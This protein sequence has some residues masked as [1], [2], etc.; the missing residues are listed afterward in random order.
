MGARISKIATALCNLFERK[1]MNIWMFNHYAQPDTLPGGTRHF[2]LART[3]VK[4]GH[5]V[6]IFAASFH[7]TLLRETQT[8][9]DKPYKKE[10][11]EGVK[12]VW[13]KTFP[14]QKNDLRRMINIL[15]YAWRLRF[16]VAKLRLKKPDVIIG[17]TVHPFAPLVASHFA[18]RYR[19]PF[20]FEIRDLWPQTFIDMQLWKKE[21][22][23][24]KL[25]YWIEKSTV[26]R[27]DGII[28]LSPLTIR[29]LEKR[30]SYPEKKILLLPNGVGE[31]FLQE[32]K[33]AEDDHFHIVYVGGID[34]VHGLDFLVLIAKT[35]ATQPHI[36]FDLYGNGKERGQLEAL[37][38]REGLENVRWHGSVIKSRVPAILKEADALFVSTSN[39]LY[40]SEN[41][42]YEYMA[43]ATPLIVAAEGKHNNPAEKIGCGISIPRDNN[44]VAA[45]KIRA[46]STMESK[47][48]IL[49]GKRGRAYVKSHRLISHLGKQLLDFLQSIP[50]S[51]R[52]QPLE[53][54][55]QIKG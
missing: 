34:R 6:T 28:V 26:K 19:V 27:S 36:V 3:L 18:K 46:L 54:G 12:F 14:Y 23:Q 38:K 11:V 24:A 49:M 8:Y 2:D 10:Q 39:V 22:L 45:E 16:A 5:R 48:R 31:Q 4:E 21:G 37:C 32:P 42:L 20:I 50:K 9:Q 15:S 30:Y 52:R 44:A 33:T 41:K 25:F 53:S 17:S 47:Q 51:K 35:L 13:V 1:P 40:G 55:L 29:Y 43:S 7:Y